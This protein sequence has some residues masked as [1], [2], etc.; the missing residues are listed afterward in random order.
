ML[1]LDGRNFDIVEQCAM[2]ESCM[3]MRVVLD[4]WL[5]ENEDFIR[6]LNS[7]Q[8]RDIY[9]KLII[10]VI[11]G[12]VEINEKLHKLVWEYGASPDSAPHF[13]HGI[14][15]NG[16]HTHL[17]RALLSRCPKTVQALIRAGADVNY[18]ATKRFI[19]RIL[20]EGIDAAEELMNIVLDA[21]FDINT[22]DTLK[23]ATMLH[24]AA[25]QGNIPIVRL[26]LRRGI[27]TNVH[28][29]RAY[30]R[31]TALHYAVQNLQQESIEVIELLMLNGEYGHSMDR[32]GR[33][34]MDILTAMVPPGP[35]LSPDQYRINLIKIQTIKNYNIDRRLA[36]ASVLH[37]RLGNRD[38][39]RLGRLDEELLR[40]VAAMSERRHGEGMQD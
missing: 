4:K 15:F 26:L 13:D 2:V 27:Q 3:H 25:Y 14:E 8:L 37:Q 28:T 5:A 31:E 19:P 1:I 22:T 40:L 32:D 29:Y 16:G 23:G 11:R 10:S 7:G 12:G 30:D 21:G 6:T 18:P 38:D 36:M 34:P 17:V 33:T 20:S 24:F 35:Y 39:C 9:D